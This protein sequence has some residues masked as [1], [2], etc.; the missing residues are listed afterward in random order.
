MAFWRGDSGMPRWRSAI[1]SWGRPPTGP[2]VGCFT[3]TCHLGRPTS[4]RL[5]NLGN[6]GRPTCFSSS[7]FVT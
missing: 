2:T 3:I 4:F 1:S 6:L 5:G 7:A